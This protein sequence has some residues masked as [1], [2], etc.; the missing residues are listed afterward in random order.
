MSCGAMFMYLER[1]NIDQ[2]E[3]LRKFNI[4]EWTL[5]NASLSCHAKYEAVKRRVTAF[6]AHLQQLYLTN[7]I[8]RS[9]LCDD[10]RI[11]YDQLE[12]L[13][14]YPDRASDTMI[15]HI[16][17]TSSPGTTEQ[18]D[19]S[20]DDDIHGETPLTTPSY[21][22]T[23]DKFKVLCGKVK[24]HHI[25][26]LIY[27]YNKTVE[28][29]MHLQTNPD[30]IEAKADHLFFKESLAKKITELRFDRNLFGLDINCLNLLD[31][32]EKDTHISNRLRKKFTRDIEY[33]RKHYPLNE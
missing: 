20:D 27:I 15:S 19:I 14:K 6:T 13:T 1:Y 9:V 8:N 29:E 22:L 3:L 17:R 21:D 10:E 5:F 7:S 31:S 12:Q 28:L 18:F 24:H 11:V 4:I 26:R 2:L 32:I 16:L 25:D 30:D 23:D 33:I